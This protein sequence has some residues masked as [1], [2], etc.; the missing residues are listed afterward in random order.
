MRAAVTPTSERF[1]GDRD[2]LSALLQFSLQAKNQ[3]AAAR[4]ARELRQL[5]DEQQ[6]SGNPR[7]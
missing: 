1:T 2:I 3:A 4:W 5:P 7:S 6:E